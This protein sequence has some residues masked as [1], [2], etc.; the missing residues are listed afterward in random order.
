MKKTTEDFLNL[1]YEKDESICVSH[2]K[3]A[4][5]SI[6]QAEIDE[7]FLIPPD[8]S[9]LQSTAI[10]EGDINLIT[11]NPVDGYRNDKNVTAFR[12]FLVELDEGSLPEQ[13]KYVKN[14]QMPYSICI[15]SGNKSLHY[16]I[17]L[18]KPLLNA[19]TWRSFNKWILNIMKKADQ[20][21]LNPSRNI[22]FPGNKRKDDKQLM[23][24]LV[25]IKERVRKSDLV[26]WLNQ[27][28]ECMPK[29]KI[30]RQRT[31]ANI[32]TLKSI[33][34][35]ISKKLEEGIFEERNKNWFSVACSFANAGYQE[36][37]TLDVLIEFYTEEDD[38]KHPEWKMCITSAFKHV[39]G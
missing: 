28:P 31:N 24:S 8:S 15:F 21:T 16:G 5:H 18:D 12:S 11:I 29:P 4:W 6:G 3:Y 7:P 17:V 33:P 14:M 38:F 1:F 34:E 22:R 19:E 13:A 20:Q 37:D 35:Y 36:E 10:K 39:R 32:P 27:H 26:D 23:Q 9:K 2:N 30:T 25:E